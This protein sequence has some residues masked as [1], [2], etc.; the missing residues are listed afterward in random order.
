MA[1]KQRI[2]NP[3]GLDIAAETPQEI[4]L[5]IVAEIQAVIGERKGSFLRDRSLTIGERLR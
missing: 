2:Y 1:Q 5:S 4:A 3:V